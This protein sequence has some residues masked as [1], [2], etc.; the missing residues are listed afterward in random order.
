[1]SP[2]VAPVMHSLG[3]TTMSAFFVFARQSIIFSV[4]NLTSPG[5]SS[6]E[7]NAIVVAMFCLRIIF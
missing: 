2:Q 6:G 4:L 1:M 5:F 7:H 3:N